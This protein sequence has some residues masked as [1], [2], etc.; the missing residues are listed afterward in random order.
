MSVNA[1]P[2]QSLPPRPSVDSLFN[3]QQI[4]PFILC[5]TM[6]GEPIKAKHADGY[7]ALK[8]RGQERETRHFIVQPTDMRVTGGSLPNERDVVRAIESFYGHSS[9]YK[10]AQVHYRPSR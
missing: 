7:L 3:D 2:P 4:G 9:N 1:R 5:F 8:P 6:D 10:L